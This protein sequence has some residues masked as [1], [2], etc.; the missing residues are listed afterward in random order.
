MMIGKMNRATKAGDRALRRGGSLLWALLL[1]VFALLGGC[2]RYDVGI[3]FWEQHHGEIVQHVQLSEQLTNLSQ[4]EANKWLRSIEARAAAL[5]GKVERTSPREL[6]VTIPFGS[7]D[8]L[9]DRFNQFFNPTHAKA[10]SATKLDNPELLQLKAELTVEQ[11]NWLLLERDRLRLTVDLRA[12]GVI[13]ERGN[14]IVSPGSLVDLQ[15]ALNTPW[16]ANAIATDEPA[17][18]PI[19]KDGQSIWQLVPGQIN[20]IEATFWVPSYLGLA[21]IGIILLV[22]AGYYLKHGELPGVASKA[23]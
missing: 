10:I 15:F 18:T 22:L 11:S 9:V 5:H 14:I 12:L 16:G 8:E 3:N 20:T 2:V 19:S 13:S 21:S 1:A 6:T 23:S 7:G 17:V 4:S